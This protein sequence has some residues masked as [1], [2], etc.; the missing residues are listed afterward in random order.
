MKRRWF[1][2]LPMLLAAALACQLFPTGGD[3]KSASDVA[4]QVAAT[5]TALA[6]G[7]NVQ[8][9]ASPTAAAPPTA[10]SPPLIAL[11]E[12]GVVY[13][14]GGHPWLWTQDDG[15]QQLS[16]TGDVIDILIS[17]DGQRVVFI[18]HEPSDQVYPVEIRAINPD[19]SGEMTLLGPADFDAIHPQQDF[20]HNDLSSVAFVPGTHNLILNTR[21]LPEGPGLLRY[22]DLLLMDADTG[23]LTTLLPAEQGGDFAVSPD[24]TKVGVIRPDSISVALIDGTIVRDEA[25]TFEPIITYSEFQYTVKPVWEQD[26]SS[27]LVAV[28]SHDPLA[29]QT[30]G[31]VWRIPADGSDPV[32]MG[33]ISGS[34]YFPQLSGGSLISPQLDKVAYLRETNGVRELFV[35]SLDAQQEQMVDTGDIDWRGWSADGL[36]FVYLLGNED[37]LQIG[38]P[39]ASPQALITGTDLTWTGADNF[40]V[41]QGSMGN[42]SLTRGWIEIG[43]PAVIAQPTGDFVKFDWARPQ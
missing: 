16:Q 32:S 5:L 20:P 11:G 17:D 3:S 33:T 1:W 6:T 37:L 42:W 21:A 41:L 29:D 12:L 35:A 38:S 7:D 2:P 22:N 15:S 34:F 27:M 8:A 19:G 10:T 36:H 14:D 4:T 9:A 13:T 18:R 24:G 31:T 26:S 40:L 25:I 28:P 23:Q 39:G 30:S 43:E